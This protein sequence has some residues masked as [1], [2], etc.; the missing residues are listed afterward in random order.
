MP[1]EVVARSLPDFISENPGT[2]V[3]VGL[4][5]LT[6]LVV[7]YIFLM[8]AI[9]GMLRFSASPVLLT[10]SF[11]SLLPLPLTLIVG[12]L[13]LIIWHFHKKTLAAHA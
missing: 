2:V 11:I 6:V 5:V 3:L 4:I 10:F 13:I 1:C 12:I 7:Y 9:L 8:R